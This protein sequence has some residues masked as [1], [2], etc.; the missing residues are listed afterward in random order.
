[1]GER[2]RMSTRRKKHIFVENAGICHYCGVKIDNKRERF[3]IA[4]VIAL[5]M[6]GRDV[7]PNCRPA[8]VDCHRD[9]TR[10]VDIPAIARVKR[11]ADRHEGFHVA[12]NP[13]PGSRD[14]P[15]KRKMDGT[16]VRRR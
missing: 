12:K 14:S 11:I 5:A 16:V 4:H 13:M 8:H 6:G 1:M 15:W 2:H 10:R 3:E 9:A 7:N